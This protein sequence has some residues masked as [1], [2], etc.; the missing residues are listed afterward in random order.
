MGENGASTPIAHPSITSEKWEKRRK[1]LAAGCLRLEDS[2]SSLE[3]E[4]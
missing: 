3:T 2:T 4:I 1:E